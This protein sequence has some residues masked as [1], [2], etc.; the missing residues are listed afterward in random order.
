MIFHAAE[1]ALMKNVL[2]KQQIKT[3]KNTNH[4]KQSQQ[5]QDSILH[6]N[7]VTISDQINQIIAE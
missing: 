1:H 2:L 5:Q 4:I 6:V 3:F 7:R